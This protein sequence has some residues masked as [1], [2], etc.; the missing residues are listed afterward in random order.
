MKESFIHITTDLLHV[1]SSEQ[2]WKY[3]IVPKEKTN[4]SVSFYT[5]PVSNADEIREFFEIVFGK[6]VCVVEKPHDV[7]QQTL[8]RY[9]RKSSTSATQKLEYNE[10][11]DFIAKLLNDAQ[12][13]NCSDIHIEVFEEEGRVR[14]RIDGKLIERYNIQKMQYPSIIN[15]IKIKANLDIAEKR[16]PQD[17]RIIFGSGSDKTDVRVSILPS[18][19]GEKAVLRLLSKNS[20]NIELETLGFQQEQLESYLEAIKKT[21][22]IVLISGPTGSG[23]TTTLYGTLKILN[24]EDTN[25][26]TIEDPI[27]YTLKGINQVQL[28]EAIGLSFSS[29]L[30]TFLRQDPDVIMLG[31]IRDGETAQMAVR[32]SLTGHL[33]FSTIHTNSAWG[34]IARLI[35]MGVPPYLVANTLNL[36]MAQRLLR[37]LCPHCKK[38]E[39]ANAELFPKG[40]LNNRKIDKHYS[41]T[42]C[43]ECYYTGYSGRTAIYEI[44]PI[45]YELSEMI[46][47]NNMDVR[48]LLSEKGI[49]TLSDNAFQLVANGTTSIAEAYPIFL[50]DF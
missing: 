31:E 11:N 15:K 41:S 6:E 10:S 50:N 22:G 1:I 20:T 44:I 23:K 18:L 7:I 8:S 28:N 30:R 21:H 42:G 14:F 2:A 27:E 12:N 29:A 32:A 40:F 19:H 49:A 37:K 39:L 4:D 33:V 5:S 25:V 45:D 26:L 13:M 34:T 9:Y 48:K 16:L 43:E 3:N 17:G 35:D 38:E 36:S 46:K 47:T 24:T